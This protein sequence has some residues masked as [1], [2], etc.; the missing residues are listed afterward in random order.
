MTL[1]V[2]ALSSAMALESNTNAVIVCS[3][4]PYVS[5]LPRHVLEDLLASCGVLGVSSGH[6]PL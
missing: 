2:G 1:S 3:S 6:C 4:P 5:F